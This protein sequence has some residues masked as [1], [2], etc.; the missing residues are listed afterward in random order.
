MRIG[1]KLKK[2]YA[3]PRVVDFGAIDVMTG[4]CFGYCLDGENGGWYG[5]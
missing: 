5:P 1:K 2:A 3:T 4:D